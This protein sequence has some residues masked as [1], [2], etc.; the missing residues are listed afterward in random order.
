MSGRV[1]WQRDGEIITGYRKTDRRQGA[2]RPL[3]ERLHEIAAA[4][5]D[6]RY[7]VRMVFV[8]PVWL[9]GFVAPGAH[10]IGVT[11]LSRWYVRIGAGSSEQ[12]F[13]KA[14]EFLRAIG[15]GHR[16]FTLTAVVINAADPDK[17]YARHLAVVQGPGVVVSAGMIEPRIYEAQ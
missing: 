5:A 13:L 8:L 9:Q 4:K 6:D 7:P 15:K 10:G 1:R 12:C 11:V 17:S 16:P 14:C 3:R 2:R